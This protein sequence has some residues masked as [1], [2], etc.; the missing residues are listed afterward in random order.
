M[1][2]LVAMVY[3]DAAEHGGLMRDAKWRPVVQLLRD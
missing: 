3:D 1:A 2:T